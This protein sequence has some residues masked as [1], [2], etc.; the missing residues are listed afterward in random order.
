MRFRSLIKGL[1]TYQLDLDE[2]IV[3]ELHF[4]KSACHSKVG[5][6]RGS[7]RVDDNVFED[8]GNTAG[9]YCSQ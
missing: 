8:M 7:T 9:T 4:S 5:K 2:V 3:S 1:E 6:R